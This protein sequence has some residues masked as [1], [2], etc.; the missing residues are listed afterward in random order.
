MMFVV[1]ASVSIG[2]ASS[3]YRRAER[4]ASAVK[5]LKSLQISTHIDAEVTRD[6]YGRLDYDWRHRPDWLSAGSVDHAN[7]Y[8]LHNVV[9]V[10]GDLWKYWSSRWAHG[11]LGLDRREQSPSR[12][13]IERDAAFWKALPGLAGLE[14]LSL[15]GRVP[16]DRIKLLR[17]F[18]QLRVLE[19]R[20]S[21]LDVESAKLIAE[22]PAIEFLDLAD[23][24]GIGGT[25]AMALIGQMPR[26]KHLGLSQ[27]AVTDVDLAVLAHSANIESLDLSGTAVSARGLAA[28]RDLRQLRRLSLRGTAAD[29]SWADELERM[30]QL[31]SLDISHTPLSGQ[32]M[33]SLARLPRLRKLCTSRTNIT[34][35]AINW[36]QEKNRT[37]EFVW[38]DR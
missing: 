17:N 33:E 12:E 36:F 23:N 18:R 32:V 9:F 7:V 10:H 37:C 29:D 2:L 4:Q 11:I 5:A 13:A 21:E 8:L 20:N 3:I 1:I 16:T 34:G 38:I 25:E 31:E 15:S 27:T 6:E 35:R 24:S 14:Q 19:L 30:T 28:L 26:L 22:L